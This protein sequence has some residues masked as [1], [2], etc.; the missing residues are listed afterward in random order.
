MT[1]SV[2]AAKEVV[3]SLQQ[4]DVTVSDVWLLFDCVIGEYPKTANRLG[5]TAYI[6][7]NGDL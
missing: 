2:Q 1:K 7:L 3:V 5:P 6:I 4:E